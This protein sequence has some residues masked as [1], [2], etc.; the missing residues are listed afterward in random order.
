MT[1]AQ[2]LMLKGLASEMPPEERATFDASCTEL[3]AALAPYMDDTE[4]PRLL[5]LAMVMS[6][7]GEK[8]GV[9]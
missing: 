4:G 2:Q 7:V 1:T 6:E 8:L 5:A 3:R 9:K